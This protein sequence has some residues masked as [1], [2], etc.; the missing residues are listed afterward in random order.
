LVLLTE[1]LA[2]TP[3]GEL[4]PSNVRELI[5]SQLGRLSSSARML[6]V[7][8]AALEQGLTFDRL[9]EVA[10]LDEQE[11]LRAL[12]E[13]LRKG[14]LCEGTLVEEQQAFNEYA[15]PREMLREVV[16]QEA[17][18]TRQRLVQRRV[19]L[20]MREEEARLLHPVLVD[21]YESAETGNE[22]VRWVESGSVG[23]IV[24]QSSAK[25]SSGAQG[26][27]SNLRGVEQFLLTIPGR[28]AGV[29]GTPEFQ[30]SPPRSS[31][32]SFL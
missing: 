4:I 32:Q 1:L 14:L 10:Q 20:L 29:Y 5:R 3:V 31:F 13:L 22:Q 15:F 25:D 26:R 27:Q 23:G 2:Q 28:S 9:I 12:E 24:H 16:Y 17:G 21:G 7:A 18:V 11:G 30:R 19:A 6:L 8:A